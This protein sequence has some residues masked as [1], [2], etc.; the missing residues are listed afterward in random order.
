MTEITV[1]DDVK[2][3]AAF[4]QKEIAASRLVAVA[5]GLAAMAPLLWG[6]YPAEAIQAMRLECSPITAERHRPTASSE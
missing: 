4:M 5:D 6:K 1:D 2:A 3:V